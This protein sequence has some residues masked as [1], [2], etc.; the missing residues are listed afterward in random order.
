MLRLSLVVIL[1]CLSC[2][3]TRSLRKRETCCMQ[4]TPFCLSCCIPECPPQSSTTQKATKPP[5]PKP[6][7]TTTTSTTPKPVVG[8]ESLFDID[9]IKV[10]SNIVINK[11]E[12]N[13][14]HPKN[15][16]DALQLLRNST[17]YKKVAHEIM[18]DRKA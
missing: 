3:N 18:K 16:D 13:G 2:A 14:F 10:P 9:D 17:I 4:Y 8:L 5:S 11:L 1:V 6:T 15:N 12:E 7:T